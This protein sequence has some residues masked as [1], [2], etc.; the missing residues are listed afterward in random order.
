MRGKITDVEAW[1]SEVKVRLMR[2]EVLV[3][4]LF[5]IEGLR[6]GVPI[7]AKMIFP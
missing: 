7:L 1:R 3:W 4:I 2:L 5:A 6:A